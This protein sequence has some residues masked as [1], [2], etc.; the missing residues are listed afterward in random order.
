MKPLVAV[1]VVVTVL[2]A[3]GLAAA[4]IT[5]QSRARELERSTEPFVASGEG[6]KQSITF[7]DDP[8]AAALDDGHIPRIQV[9]ALKSYGQLIRPRTHFVP[10]M[11]KSV[12]VL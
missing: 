11:L 10:E 9:R 8:L 6:D 7:S 1:L 3:S 5:Q 4:Q 2:S 12:E